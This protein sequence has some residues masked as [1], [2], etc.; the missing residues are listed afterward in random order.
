MTDTP[1][2]SAQERFDE[3]YI[4]SREICKDLDVSRATILHARKRG[5]LPDPI[6]VNNLQIFLWERE[7]LAPYLQSWR[8]SLASRRGE[9]AG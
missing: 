1:K 8:L 3:K 4:S 7:T 5:F 9:L 6:T 2:K